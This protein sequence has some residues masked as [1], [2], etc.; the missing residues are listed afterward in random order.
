[1]KKKVVKMIGLMMAAVLALGCTACGSTGGEV[2]GQQ[3]R[4]ILLRNHRM[5]VPGQERRK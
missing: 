3:R 1:M 5:T 4:M 2:T